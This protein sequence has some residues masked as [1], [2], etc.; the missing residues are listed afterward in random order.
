M[1]EP[2]CRHCG[3]VRYEHHGFEAYVVPPGCVCD[4]TGWR[5]PDSIP[6][7][8]SAFVKHPLTGYGC[9]NC[10]HDTTCH[11]ARAEGSGK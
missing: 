4:P 10:E 5:D 1:T 9:L 7:I 6:A 11:A 8:C 3:E 2:I